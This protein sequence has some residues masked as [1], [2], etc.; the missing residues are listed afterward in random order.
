MQPDQ[1]FVGRAL[2][3]PLQRIMTLLALLLVHGI[4]HAVHAGIVGTPQQHRHGLPLR[5]VRADAAI[6]RG[7]ETVLGRRFIGPHADPQQSEIESRRHDRRR[8]RTQFLDPSV[9]RVRRSRPRPVRYVLRR[10]QHRQFVRLREAAR[11]VELVQQRG[12]A[13]LHDGGKVVR[14][15]VVHDSHG[16]QGFQ[17]LA[18]A[19]PIAP[20]RYPLITRNRCHSRSLRSLHGIAQLRPPFLGKEGCQFV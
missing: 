4:A 9:V 8:Q 14:V 15:S 10:D 20:Q 2:H 1:F 13:I 11:A 18:E 12:T 3:D 7:Q 17:V 16:A 5:V 6:E 19:R